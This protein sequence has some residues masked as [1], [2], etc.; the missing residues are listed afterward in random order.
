M[1]PPWGGYFP[2]PMRGY[3]RGGFPGYRGKFSGLFGR[4]GL[5][6][7]VRVKDV[8]GGDEAEGGGEGETD[9]DFEVVC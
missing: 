1:Y 2:A 6:P 7:T 4:C 3:P 5:V 9:E 8:T